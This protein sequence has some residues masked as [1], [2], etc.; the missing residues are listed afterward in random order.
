MQGS[1][2]TFQATGGSPLLN[3]AEALVSKVSYPKLNIS[4][5]DD[6]ISGTL[7]SP[8]ASVLRNGEFVPPMGIAL[9]GDEHVYVSDWLNDQ[10]QKFTSAGVL[11][12]SLGDQGSNDGQ[13]QGPAGIAVDA[14]GNVYVADAGNSR[15]QKFS[16]RGEF[17]T[18]WGSEGHRDGRFSRSTWIAVDLSGNVFVTDP[19]DSRVRKFSLNGE[20]LSHLGSPGIGDG[21]FLSP[22][23][24]AVDGLGNIYVVH[25]GNSRVQV[26]SPSGAYLAKWGSTGI[27]D[28]QV[29]TL[30]ASQ[31]TGRATFM[32]L[33][34]LMIAYRYSGRA[35]SV[36]EPAANEPLKLIRLKPVDCLLSQTRS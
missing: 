17:L 28:G 16:S 25:S 3:S 35:D 19:V 7:K 9:D 18:K 4:N 13:F 8:V 29:K 11:L 34:P 14:E 20:F 6:S 24:I 21:E 10:V 33:I 32:W 2:S 23:G 12:M 36:S 15:V 1:D 27:G 5:A 26:L 31:W 30:W 22:Q